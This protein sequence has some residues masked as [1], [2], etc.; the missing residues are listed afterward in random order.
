M[1][2]LL[3]S[4]FGHC[5]FEQVLLL[6]TQQALKLFLKVVF[7]LEKQISLLS[8][9]WRN[10]LS[11]AY[12]NVFFNDR[13][14]W[15]VCMSKSLE[16]KHPWCTHWHCYSTSAPKTFDPILSTLPLWTSERM[17]SLAG[18]IAQWDNDDCDIWCS[19]YAPSSYTRYCAVDKAAVYGLARQDSW[20]FWQS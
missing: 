10:P 11:C 19:S 12:V 20:Q 2:C 1:Q 15:R 7:K 17:R 16:N 3:P 14:A 5:Q 18:Y 13:S 6:C 8:M 9:Q 4:V